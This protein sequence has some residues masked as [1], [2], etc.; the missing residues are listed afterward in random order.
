M[1]DNKCS[2]C[3]YKKPNREPEPVPGHAFEVILTAHQVLFKR[4]IAVIIILVVLLVGSNIGWIIYESQ[5][6]TVTIEQDAENGYNNAIGGDGD[7]FNG[8][9]APE[10]NDPAA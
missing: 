4:L 6:E 9:S 10:D 1:A 7:I 2:K 3:A 8:E 5:F